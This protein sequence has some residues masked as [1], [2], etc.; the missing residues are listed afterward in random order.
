MINSKTTNGTVNLLGNYKL[1][2]RMSTNNYKAEYTR[3]FPTKMSSSNFLLLYTLFLLASKDEPL[4]GKEMLRD[5]QSNVNPS[6]WNPS[7]GT[8]YPLL[9]DMVRAGYIEIAGTIASKK[10]YSITKLGKEELELKLAEFKPILVKAA[11][12]FS[13]LFNVMYDDSKDTSM[14]S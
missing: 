5:I 2:R 8:Y 7:H 11:N 1:R 4:Y 3:I 10:L 13:K 6:I 12:F 9:E 14:T